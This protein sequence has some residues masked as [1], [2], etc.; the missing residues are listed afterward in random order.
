[1]KVLSPAAGVLCVAAGLVA[2]C[3]RLDP[4]QR[5]GMWQPEGVN[6]RNIAAMVQD[7]RD[8][9]HGRGDGGPAWN[10]GA[11]AVDRL[12]RDKVKPFPTDQTQAPSGAD[13]GAGPGDA[14]PQPG[15]T[16]QSGGG[17]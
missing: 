13:S 7:P 8:L 3:A 9:A 14:T 1:M 16:P 11:A 15:A 10:T 5:P 2:G 4:Y 17:S 6:D 12:W